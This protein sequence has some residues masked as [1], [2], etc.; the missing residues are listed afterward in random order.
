VALNPSPNKRGRPCKK[1]SP[2]RKLRGKYYITF[3][4]KTEENKK[5]YT[6]VDSI[7]RRILCSV[8]MMGPTI[9]DYNKRLVL[10]SVIQLSGGNCTSKERMGRGL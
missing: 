1:L 4:N 6:L 5:K 9:F 8:Y 10:L 3:K 7:N 2:L